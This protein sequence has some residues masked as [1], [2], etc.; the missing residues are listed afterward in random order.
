V[1]HTR[2]IQ[3]DRSQR[4]G[5]A[6]I[7][8]E[9]GAALKSLVEPATFRVAEFLKTAGKRE[10]TLGLS[11]MLGIVLSLIWRQIGSVCELARVIERSVV[12]WVTPR[13]VTQQAINQRLRSMPA[14]AF[15]H[16]L[17]CPRPN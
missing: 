15:E 5:Y 8:V 6:A 7:D 13:K 1:R 16:V 17:I 4:S 14:E 12:L 3:H 11:V 10:R 2:S 9:I